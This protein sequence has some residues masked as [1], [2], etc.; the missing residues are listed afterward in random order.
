MGLVP[1]VLA[2]IVLAFSL[3]GQPGP[4]GTSLAP[5]AYSGSAAF[6]TLN[7]LARN[8]PDRQPGSSGDD[9]PGQLRRPP[10]GPGG[11]QGLN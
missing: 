9:A 5:Q 2:A 4:L 7:F 3:T 10:A 6:G 11:I 1:I 8:Y